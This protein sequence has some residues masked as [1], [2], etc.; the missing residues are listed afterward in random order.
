MNRSTRRSVLGAGV[1]A[2]VGLLGACATNKTDPS[3]AY[4]Q[5]DGPQVAAAETARHPGRVNDITLNAAVSTVDLGGRTVSAWTY[6]GSV[7][8]PTLRLRAGEQI[9]ATLVNNL[10]QP[11]SVHWH[12][13]AL[14]NN[15]D[16][17]PD[18]T[19]PAVPSGG[20]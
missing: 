20:Q 1:A 11:T 5:P 13:L 7:A 14:R 15:A 12:G 2:G 9:R 8:G 6:N 18:V 19:Q 17:V 10:P 16:G 4:V 3:A